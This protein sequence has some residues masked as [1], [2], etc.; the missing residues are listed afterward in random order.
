MNI[1][2]KLVISLLTLAAFS[3]CTYEP[4]PQGKELYEAYCSNCHSSD[5]TGLKDLIPDIRNSTYYST[6]KS[7]LACIIKHGLVAQD[8]TQV[9]MDMPPAPK[10][11]NFEI[12]NII[13]YINHQ[14][15]EDFKEV[16]ILDIDAD[17]ENCVNQK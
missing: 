13:N 8:S 7:Q 1:K 15:N 17:L 12:S 11:S 14:W 3:H 10:L 16:L 2:S 9:I 6:R 5:G 4:Y